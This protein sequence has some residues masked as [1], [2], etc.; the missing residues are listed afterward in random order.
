MEIGVTYAA[1]FG[2]HENLTGGGNGN[3]ALA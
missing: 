1:S 2:L 3:V